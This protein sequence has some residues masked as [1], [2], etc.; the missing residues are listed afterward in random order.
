MY[1]RKQRFPFV[2]TAGL[3]SVLL[4][5]FVIGRAVPA[6][7]NAAPAPVILK[8]VRM[9]GEL[10][11]VEHQ[12]QTVLEVESHLPPA[13]WTQGIPVVSQAVGKAVETATKNRALV[14]VQGSVEAGVDLSKA[15]MDPSGSK[16][17]V[18]LPHATVYPAQVDAQLHSQTHAIGW[19][20]RNLA[21]KARRKGAE[22]F[23]SA[24]LSAGILRAAEDRARV[25]VAGMFRSAGVE[26]V[27]I[28]FADF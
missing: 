11:L 20:D 28:K 10:H 16:L 19:D 26:S 12:Y 3:A 21:L 6:Q 1:V 7:P 24:S 4:V 25:Q 18:V 8:Q 27:Q 15:K 13:E 2:A 14:S 9:L 23:E 5:G 22:R 17:T